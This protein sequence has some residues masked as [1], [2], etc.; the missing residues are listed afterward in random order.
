MSIEIVTGADAQANVASM[1]ANVLLMGAPG[2]LKTQDALEAF[3]GPDGKCHAFVIPCEDGALKTWL[4]RGGVVPDH[5]KQTVKSWA[6]LTETIAWVA[7]NRTRYSAVVLDGLTPLSTYLYNEATETL[8]GKNKFDIPVKVRS[9]L[10]SLREWIR[11]LG[12]HSVFIAHEEPP[13]V[14]EGIFYPGA[15]KLSPRSMTRE[16]FGQL[17]T[18][19]RVAWYYTI[20][21]PPVRVYY[22]GGEV[23]PTEL[24]PMPPPDLAQWLTKNREGC[25]YAVMPANLLAFLRRRV[26]P[27]TGL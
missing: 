7:Q 14:Q 6:A 13:A 4:S 3:T 17:D 10:F 8:K 18:V 24:G 21:R 26:P 9:Q 22:T 27:Y 15:M 23:W 2:T 1:P 12:L 11:M 19:L 20:G 5:P 25:N 16:Y